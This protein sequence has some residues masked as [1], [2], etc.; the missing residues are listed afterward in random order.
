MKS[1]LYTHEILQDSLKE[2]GVQAET[3]NEAIS[4]NTDMKK[5]DK[6][7]DEDQVHCSWC[8]F[9]P[10]KRSECPAKDAVCHRCG[11]RGHFKSVC[12]NEKR[13]THRSHKQNAFSDSSEYEYDNGETYDLSHLG[14]V[15][16]GHATQF[17][18]WSVLF[19][20]GREERILDQVTRRTE[21]TSHGIQ[22]SIQQVMFCTSNIRAV[23]GFV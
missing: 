1:V 21:S 3:E 8:G 4:H 10:H 7:Q 14:G 19:Y 2:M 11:R 23:R 13:M 6:K 16:G 17:P 18:Q 22:Y 20:T 12:F 5:R 9:D 15:L